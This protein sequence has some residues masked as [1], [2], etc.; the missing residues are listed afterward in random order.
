VPVVVVFD[1]ITAVALGAP[2]SLSWAASQSLQ[3]SRL[4]CILPRCDGAAPAVP[5]V[6]A[7]V[8][9]VYLVLVVV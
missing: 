2:L 5:I 4:L 6:A 7:V 8:A 9:V 3:T 1:V